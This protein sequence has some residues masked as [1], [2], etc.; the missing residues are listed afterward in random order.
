MYRPLNNKV[1]ITPDKVQE[2]VGGLYSAEQALSKPTRGTVVSANSKSELK[3][4]DIVI[5]NKHAGQTI[6]L[7]DKEYLLMSDDDIYFIE[8]A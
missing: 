5:Y 4:G 1:L 2:T 3:E 7:D 8:H 6:T